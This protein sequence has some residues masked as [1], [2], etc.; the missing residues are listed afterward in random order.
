MHRPTDRRREPAAERDDHVAPRVVLREPGGRRGAL[1]ERLDQFTADVRVDAAVRTRS[2]ERWLR[3]QAE[4]QSTLAGVLADLRDQATAVEVRTRGGGRYRAVVRALGA[5]HVVLA[6][7]HGR[8]EVLVPLAA[9]QSVRTSPGVAPVLGDR[10]TVG[11]AHL[12]DA[13]AELADER[14][15]IRV[16]TDGADV[17]A[18]TVRS[19]GQDIVVVASRETPAVAVYVPLD[20]I[21]AVI[22]ER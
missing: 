21:S 13:L 15:E 11:A 4:E 18:G 17:A 1:D 8:G 14:A 9:L 20:G 5:D 6:D 22:V 3:R 12:G 19:V 7:A 16:V 2:R 10:T